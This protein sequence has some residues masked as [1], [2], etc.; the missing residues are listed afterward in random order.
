MRAMQLAVPCVV[1][2]I[3][4]AGQLQAALIVEFSEVGGDTT[5][6][7]S[8]SLEFTGLAFSTASVGSSTGV[9]L[10][11]SSESD[12]DGSGVLWNTGIAV[13]EYLSPWSSSP[14]FTAGPDFEDVG[15]PTFTQQ[16]VLFSDL[17]LFDPND[18]VGDVWSGSGVSTFSGVPLAS[19]VNVDT[20]VVW[21]LDNSAA[22]TVTWQ[23]D[24]AAAVPEP[25]SFALFGIGACVAGVGA[26]RRRR[27]EKQ[28][29]ATI[30]EIGGPLALG[31]GSDHE[32]SVR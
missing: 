6:S 28:Q 31:S 11:S 29:V 5:M 25:S 8:G 1:V 32:P 10:Y 9:G 22:D 23:N 14:D 15:T 4:A 7:Y 12:E 19:L 2:L 24:S 3:A 13:R 17:V 21:T 30:G 20:P 26:A 16:F 27:R 18:F